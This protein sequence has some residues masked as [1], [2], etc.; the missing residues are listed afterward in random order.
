MQVFKIS[1]VQETDGYRKGQW[2]ATFKR[3]EPPSV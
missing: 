2:Y 3:T 1:V